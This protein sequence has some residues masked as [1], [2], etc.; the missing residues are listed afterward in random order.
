MDEE[1]RLNHEVEGIWDV[2]CSELGIL[3]NKKKQDI[4]REYGKRLIKQ[5]AILWRKG[6][7]C[8]MCGKEKTDVYSYYCKQH[9]H[10]KPETTN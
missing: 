4:V 6:K 2:L 1:T 9:K 8:M 7:R 10:E 5:E 3:E